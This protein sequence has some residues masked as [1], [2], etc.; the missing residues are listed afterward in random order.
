MRFCTSKAIGEVLVAS[1]RRCPR[2]EAVIRRCQ[3]HVSQLAEQ[4][5]ELALRGDAEGAARTLLAEGESTLNAKLLEMAALVA[6][7]YHATFD[8]ADALA[9]RARTTLQR[10]CRAGN[11]I[12]GIQRSGR[13]PGGLQIRG[14]SLAETANAAA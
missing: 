7:R 10:T 3:A 4:A 9:E 11:H 5:M 1:A 14:R 12:A 6:R 8:D 2:D 13:S